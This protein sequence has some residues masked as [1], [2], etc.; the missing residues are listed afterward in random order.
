MTQ[1]VSELSLVIS[2][3]AAAIAVLSFARARLVAASERRVPRRSRRE[4]PA[5]L[6]AQ[7]L[8]IPHADCSPDLE[9]ESRAGPYSYMFMQFKRSPDDMWPREKENHDAYVAE[10]LQSSQEVDR[11]L[12]TKGL[13]LVSVPRNSALVVGSQVV[14]RAGAGRAGRLEDADHALAFPLAS[15]VLLVLGHGSSRRE[16]AVL[17]ADEVDS[18]NLATAGYCQEIAG[19]DPVTVRRAATCLQLRRAL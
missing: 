6:Q 10:V 1:F 7:R 17:S 11:V 2:F 4:R 13:C 14:L 8:Q 18:A 5:A 15:D 9:E 3:V 16:H 12:K 19:P